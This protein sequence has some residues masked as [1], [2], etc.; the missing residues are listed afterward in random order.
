MTK[1]RYDVA[2]WGRNFLRDCN[3]YVYKLYFHMCLNWAGLMI[4]WAGQISED[5][6]GRWDG[7]SLDNE[8][9][10]S[11]WTYVIHWVT[12]VASLQI[13][14]NLCAYLT[15]KRELKWENECSMWTLILYASLLCGHYTRCNLSPRVLNFG[16]QIQML[17]QYVKIDVSVPSWTICR[18]RWIFI[19][20]AQQYNQRYWAT[21]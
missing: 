3:I 11:T 10:S 16:V 15:C 5:W 8:I 4:R 14:D 21:I 1:N 18:I 7:T 17:H 2:V 12:L 6:L 20:L 13:G 19:S 9:S